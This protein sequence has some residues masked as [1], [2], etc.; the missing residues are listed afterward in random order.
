MA[1]GEDR[2]VH[3]DVQAPAVLDG[4]LDQPVDVVPARRVGLDKDRFATVV[5]DQ[6]VRGHTTFP[7]LETH[8]SYDDARFFGGE[9]QRHRAAQTR[10]AAGHHDRLPLEPSSQL[11]SP[12]AKPPSIS[13]VIPVM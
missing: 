4:G 9:G 6:F 10:G 13:T 7:R 2:V 11:K 5:I 12:L 8:V 1:A 3:H